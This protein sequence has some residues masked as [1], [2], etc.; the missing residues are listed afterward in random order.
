[1]TLD[2]GLAYFQHLS[3]LILRQTLFLYE[4][5]LEKSLCYT[6]ICFLPYFTLKVL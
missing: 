4:Q 6:I 3:N 1:M 2:N 5:Q